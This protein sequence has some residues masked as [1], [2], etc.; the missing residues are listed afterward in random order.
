MKAQPGELKIIK[1]EA[2]QKPLNV[3]NRINSEAVHEVI[4]NGAE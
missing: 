2:V 4:P 3:R 1:R